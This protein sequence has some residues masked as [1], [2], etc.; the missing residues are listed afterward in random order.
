M[1]LRRLTEYADRL[2]LPPEMYE[3]VPVTWIVD[4]D[5]DGGLEGFVRLEDVRLALPR[6][7][8]E[9][10]PRVVADTAK[11]VLGVLGS[12]RK[13]AAFVELVHKCAEATAEAA[14]LAVLAFLQRPAPEVPQ[15]MQGSDILVFRVEGEIVSDLPRVQRFWARYSVRDDALPGRCLVTGEEGDV[16]R[17]LPGKIKGVPG[18]PPRGVALVSAKHEATHHYGLDASL[19]LPISRR[20]AEKYTGALN[21]LLR[22]EKSRVRVGSLSYVFWTREP[23]ALGEFASLLTRPDPER[24]RDLLLSPYK[25]KQQH[26]IEA[27]AFYALA[28]SG[29]PGRIVVRDYLETTVPEVEENLKRWFEAQRITDAWGAAGNPLGIF[30]LAA[31]AY[32]E[33]KDM[34]PRVLTGLLNA[35]L[36]GQAPP[37]ELLSRAVARNRVE[38]DKGTVTRQRAALIKTVLTY[39]GEG[40]EIMEQ[41]TAYHC[42]RLL[43]ELEAAQAAASPRI[44]TTLVDKYFG[45]ASTT[46]APA[47]GMLMKLSRPHMS[48]LKR[49]KPGLAYR[50]EERIAGITTE[51]GTEFP[52]PLTL[53]EQAVFALG[54]YNQRAA[55]RAERK[56]KAQARDDGRAGEQAEEVS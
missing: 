16:E 46:P 17:I 35:A 25:G 41:T 38:A 11:Y 31:S 47:F 40:G 13:H 45:M 20:A 22:D 51:I 19:N 53:R 21:A 8:K 18:T 43:A 2:D 26:G 6:R 5:A 36:K 29:N 37:A 48:K 32:F 3:L 15:D 54:F 42:G 27:D 4:L 1:I 34:Q 49:D 9:N 10:E 52:P 39:R 44:D 28:L 7:R 56:A 30:A 23:G 12:E 24:V 55:T 33:P 14:V 50:L